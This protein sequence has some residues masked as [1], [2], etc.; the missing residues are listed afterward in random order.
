MLCE[1]IGL[2]GRVGVVN[3]ADVGALIV[4][5]SSTWLVTSLLCTDCFGDLGGVTAVVTTGQVKSIWM[6]LESAL[7]L[8]VVFI[9][10]TG[11]KSGTRSVDVVV[12]VGIILVRLLSCAFVAKLN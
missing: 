8:I 10:A 3:A 4:G 5:G 1:C 7:S 11:S 12:R 2:C 9:S 6:V